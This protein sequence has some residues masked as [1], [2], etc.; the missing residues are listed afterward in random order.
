MAH[1]GRGDWAAAVRGLEDASRLDPYSP[2]VDFFLGA[3][4]LMTGETD[5]A[6]ERL[7]RVAEAS[8]SPFS[9]E[10][11][12]YLAKA[13]LQRGAVDEARAELL[14]LVE[15]PS[16]LEADAAELIQQIDRLR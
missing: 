15:S 7:R 8:D 16:G 12:Y 13:L 3:S 2:E 6:V 4:Y 14:A 9:D 11:R 1:Y 10:G 5:R